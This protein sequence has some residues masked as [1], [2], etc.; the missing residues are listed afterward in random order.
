MIR[1]YITWRTSAPPTNAHGGRQQ[2]GRFPRR[3]RESGVTSDRASTAAE[4]K[5]SFSYIS[6]PTK[7]GGYKTSHTHMTGGTD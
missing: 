2:G 5:R 1:H 7:K 6:I 4:H 3:R